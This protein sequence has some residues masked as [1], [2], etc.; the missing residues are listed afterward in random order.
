ML[1]TLLGGRAFAEKTGSGPTRVVALHGWARTRADWAPVLADTDALALDL[2][3]HGATPEPDAAWG[4]A[5]YADFVIEVLET[6]DRPVL[7]GH[8]F[9]G[10]VAITVAAKRPD[11]VRGVVL[12]GVPLLRKQPTG[13]GRKPALGYRVMRALHR[14]GLVGDDKMEQLRRKHGSADYANA[15]GVMRE[16]LVKLVNEDYREELVTVAE[17]GVP[18]AMVWGEHDTAAPVPMAREALDLLGEVATLTVVPG[19]AHLLD[20]ALVAELQQ[21]IA[22]LRESEPTQT[23]A[24]TDPST[25]EEE[26]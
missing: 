4:A 2:P 24:V 12:T 1:T 19:S 20:A 25:P 7:A 23:A 18:V 5:E 3:G 22:V 15:R 13:G 26:R 9:G 21:A 17:H 8:S 14:R 6:L 10:R 11:L 16:I